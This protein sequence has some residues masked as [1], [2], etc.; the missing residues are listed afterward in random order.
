MS[1]GN[2][3]SLEMYLDNLSVSIGSTKASKLKSQTSCLKGD[4]CYPVFQLIFDLRL[5][6][7]F[8][9]RLPCKT[10]CTETLKRPVTE[11]EIFE[12]YFIRNLQF[13]DQ[14]RNQGY[15]LNSVPKN[16]TKVACR[17]RL[18]TQK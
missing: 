11:C 4:S 17:L 10:L 3:R 18:V 6:T 7:I 8:C 5:E 15:R 2:L 12:R 1:T 16:V 14:K 13:F 9:P